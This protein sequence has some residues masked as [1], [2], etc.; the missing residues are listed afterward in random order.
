MS[1]SPSL[2]NSLPDGRHV[3]LTFLSLPGSSL[4]FH[5]FNFTP[6][7]FF[8]FFIPP[9]FKMVN[10][11]ST[12]N[13][14]LTSTSLLFPFSLRASLHQWSEALFSSECV[15]VC[16]CVCVCVIYPA[17]HVCAGCR[18]LAAAVCMCLA[19]M[20]GC[21]CRCGDAGRASWVWARCS[22]PAADLPPL[23]DVEDPPDT[24]TDKE[25]H[26]SVEEHCSV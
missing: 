21:R 9:F 15:F 25:V 22:G 24:H 4:S 5:L 11:L 6:P 19:G 18:V 8:L 2:R 26:C 3:F 14:T 12:F 10:H 1:F 7:P 17:V 16:V 23:Y 20:W 13:I